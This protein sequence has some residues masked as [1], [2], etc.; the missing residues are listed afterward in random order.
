MAFYLVLLCCCYLQT[1]FPDWHYCLPGFVYSNYAM[2]LTTVQR[3][4][5]FFF[6]DNNELLMPFP[7]RLAVATDWTIIVTLQI[8]SISYWWWWFRPGNYS[9]LGAIVSRSWV[10][11]FVRCMGKSLSPR[12]ACFR[13]TSGWRYAP[14]LLYV[15]APFQAGHDFPIVFYL[16]VG[17]SLL[18]YIYSAP[19]LKV[20]EYFCFI[21]STCRF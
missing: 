1:P 7:R 3:F 2:L 19:P 18:S 6:L 10:G 15:F 5:W 14:C 16:A 4:K 11:C 9:D 12:K 8:F 17:G 13:I 21:R 20:I